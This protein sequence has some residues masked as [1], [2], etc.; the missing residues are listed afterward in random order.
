MESN[1]DPEHYL[2][3]KRER[4]QPSHDLVN[5]IEIVNPRSIIDIGCGPGNSTRV[6]WE[7]WPDASVVGLDSSETMIDTATRD[8]PDRRWICAD[9]N[10]L[11]DDPQYD[12]VF[13]NATIQWIPDHEGLIRNLMGRVNT[14]GA[15]AVQIPLFRDM[16]INQEIQALTE[17]PRW[18]E[19]LSGIERRFTYERMETYYDIVAGAA[20]RV[21]M[22]QTWYVHEMA[23]HE[24]IVHMMSST[25]L[26]P[27]LD[28]LSEDR[29]EEFLEDLLSNIRRVYPVQANGT[30]LYP[31]K[32]LFFIGY[33]T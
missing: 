10:D 20:D 28:A 23:S 6:L 12:L 2:R 11:A 15:L 13:S 17:H 33:R 26:R 9:V 14:G 4:T 5:R 1:W 27:Y 32:R 30:V 25:G 19:A 31:F 22:W 7:R 3:F 18:N 24:M 16:P 21:T 8:H 29:R